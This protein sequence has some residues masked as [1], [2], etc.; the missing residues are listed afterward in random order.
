MGLHTWT[1]YNSNSTSFVERIRTL[2]KSKAVFKERVYFKTVNVILICKI[3]RC[4][5]DIIIKDLFD[6]KKIIYS[7]RQ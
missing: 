7:D 2:Q 5:V 3:K 1:N 4:I 6:Y